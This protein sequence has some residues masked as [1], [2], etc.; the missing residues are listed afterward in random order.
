MMR[1]RSLLPGL[2]FVGALASAATPNMEAFVDQCPAK[3]PSAAIIDK[4]FRIL[5]NGVQVSPVTCTEPVTAMAAS[6]DL[7]VIRIQQTLR[8]IYQMDFDKPLTLPWTSL[9]MYDWVKS[10]IAGVNIDTTSG[11]SYCCASFGGKLFFAYGVLNYNDFSRTYGLRLERLIGLL[12]LFGHQGR[13]VARFY[14]HR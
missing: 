10:K 1:F 8:L 7:D 12:P 11:N 4:D 5:R 13:R 3:D 2:F 6:P 9:R 14:P